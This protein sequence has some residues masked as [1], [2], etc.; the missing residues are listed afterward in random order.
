[1]TIVFVSN[2]FNHH[3]KPFSDAMDELT[4]HNYYFIA[5]EEM[6][7]ERKQLGWGMED[8]PPYVKDINR[9]REE[10]AEC[11]RLIDEADVV[12]FGSMPEKLLKNRI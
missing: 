5:T 9:N 8:F 6:T 11:V 10:Q 4:E 1:M 2:Y 3:Q 12:L 7:E